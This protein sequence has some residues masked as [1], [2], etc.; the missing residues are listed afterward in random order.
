MKRRWA[1]LLRVAVVRRPGLYLLEVS[2][3]GVTTLSSRT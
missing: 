1:V 3:V 2:G